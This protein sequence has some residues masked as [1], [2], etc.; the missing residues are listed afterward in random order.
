MR[1]VTISPRLARRP[2]GAGLG[3]RVEYHYGDVVEP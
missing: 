2:G 3:D 1:H